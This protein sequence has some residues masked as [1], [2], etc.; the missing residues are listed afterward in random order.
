MFPSFE[1]VLSVELFIVQ[2]YIHHYT[3]QKESFFADGVSWYSMEIHREDTGKNNC[4]TRE[5]LRIKLLL[6]ENEVELCS[7][8]WRGFVEF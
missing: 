2:I 4:W 1:F 8:I 3:I 7:K 6:Y 5:N